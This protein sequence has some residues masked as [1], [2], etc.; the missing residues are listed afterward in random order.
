MN[1]LYLI[2]GLPGSGKTTFAN[3]M[4][5][6]LHGAADDAEAAG[7]HE[8]DDYMRDSEGNYSFDAD[9]LY[10][11][12]E[13]C[14]AAASKDLEEGR[15]TIV[16]NTSTTEKEIE[17]YQELAAYFGARFVSIIVENR[18]GNSSVHNVPELTMDKMRKRFSVQL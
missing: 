17:K 13:A 7:R 3:T 8:A 1:T 10:F 2:R 15:D 9:K 16:S 18:H 11:C 5:A 6:L 14:F 4:L 12:H